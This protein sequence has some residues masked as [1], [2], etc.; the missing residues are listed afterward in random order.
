VRVPVWLSEP[1]VAL[2]VTVLVPAGVP[3]VVV[4]PLPPLPPPPLLLFDPPPQ[5]VR[6]PPSA[7]TSTSPSQRVCRTR[8]AGSR[9][10]SRVAIPAA[11]VKPVRAGTV[12]VVAAVVER[13]RVVVTALAPGVMVLGEKLQAAF[14]G[15]PL[16][17]K[18]TCWEKPPA[19]VMVRV[20]V[21]L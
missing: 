10:N 16:Q 7:R 12:L 17:A 15:S 2:T 5:A 6:K 11:R 1:E 20:E 14:A 13:V 19:G 3:G 18:L 9:N 8:V 4:W 21:P